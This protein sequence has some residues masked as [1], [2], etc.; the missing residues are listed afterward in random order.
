[1]IG[2]RMVNI[3][4]TLVL[5]GSNFANACT[6]F[7]GFYEGDFFWSCHEIVQRDCRTQIHRGYSI[8]KPSPPDVEIEFITDGVYRRYVIENNA[9]KAFQHQ[10]D[11][12][13]WFSAL[14]D[15]GRKLFSDSSLLP[16]GNSFT[17]SIW[18]S[19]DGKIEDES[20]HE[21]KRFPNLKD[22]LASGAVSP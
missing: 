16:N 21:M 3:I 15:D 11:G 13:L 22:C 19:A 14:Y 7:S 1:M 18:Y 8:T 2:E 4:F 12:S 10:P 6:D 9:Q 17:K 20:A 5:L